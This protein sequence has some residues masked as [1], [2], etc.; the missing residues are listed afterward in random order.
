[1]ET[2]EKGLL[3]GLTG[4]QE[5]KSQSTQGI[6]QSP[7]ESHLGIQAKKTKGILIHG[8]RRDSPKPE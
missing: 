3:M 4:H 2:K 8:T 7:A 6:L 5:V 1:M